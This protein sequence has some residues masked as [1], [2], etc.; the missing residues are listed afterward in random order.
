V[1]FA[2]KLARRISVIG[3]AGTMALAA[4]S[5]VAHAEFA[6]PPGSVVGS[7]WQGTVS[8]TTSTGSFT[9]SLN[10]SVFDTFAIEGGNPFDV[11]VSTAGTW[12]VIAPARGKLRFGTNEACWGSKAMMDV[13]NA[14]YNATT[15]TYSATFVPTWEPITSSTWTTASSAT[16]CI[17]KPFSGTASYTWSAD[18]RSVTGKI[19]LTSRSITGCG[20]STYVATVKATYAGDFVF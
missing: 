8:G 10:L 9:Q 18:F 7:L 5:G 3:V 17:Y 2:S 14:S 15:R 19:N 12:G 11:C 16:A 1:T 13:V 20:K 4:M 6:N